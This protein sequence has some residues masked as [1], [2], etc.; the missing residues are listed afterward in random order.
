MT[1]YAPPAWSPSGR[2]VFGLY[3]EVIKSG[4]V[5]ETIAL[6]RP[7]ARSYT[8]VGRL[9]TACDVVLVHASI[10][11]VH[12]VLQFDAQGAL[13]LYD[14][15]S[16][17]GS[18]VNKRRIPAE[19]FVR[20]EVGDVLAFGE[21]TRR[22]A[23]C[24]PVERMPAES[25]SRTL[26]TLR[27]HGDP[28][29][30]GTTQQEHEHDRGVSWG[31]RQD[32]EEEEERDQEEEEEARMVATKKEQLP[33]YLRHLT[34]DDRPYESSLRPSQ[35]HPKDQRLYEQVQTRIR[36]MENLKLE[37]ARILA[38]QH[39][40][41]GLSAGQQQ[42]VLRNEERMEALRKDIEALEARIH[43]KNEQRA[44]A[45]GIRGAVARTKRQ[46]DPDVYGYSSDEDEFYD[47]TSANRAKLA[48]RK[49]KM[50]DT[51]TALHGNTRDSSAPGQKSE[52]LTAE[53]IR[54]NVTQLEAN[55]S[56]LQ[57]DV[58]A[59]SRTASNQTAESK[60]EHEMDSL[61]SFMATTST[62]LQMS[63]VEA[64]TRQKQAVEEELK[65]QKQ[66]LAVA[67]PAL[68]AL[69]IQKPIVN[70]VEGTVETNASTS[71]TSPARTRV[72]VKRLTIDAEAQDEAWKSVVEPE[73]SVAKE[74]GTHVDDKHKMHPAGSKHGPNTIVETP[75]PESTGPKRRRI[76]GPAKDAWE[77]WKS[78][79]SDEQRRVDSNLLEGGDPSW[80]PPA[81]QTGDGRTALNDKYG[82]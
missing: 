36:K 32:A 38:K 71:P 6:P 15:R 72:H 77:H 63:H 55:L 20:L 48:A 47:R 2:N 49:Q 30:A 41:D 68:A 51:S 33:E 58:T 62:Q 31:F 82:Y 37:R 17:H 76:V 54:A 61:D 25:E 67:T 65:R 74:I 27:E 59:A 9:A 50:M 45:S 69:P 28:T 8:F 64:L 60:E 44:T 1:Q 57:D 22:V 34:E 70:P 24:G 52:I 13:F 18:I 5:V 43:A 80:V 4:V 66:L 39:T 21:S 40:G 56:K 12:A 78:D 75:E 35:V 14:L 73:A 29:R 42:T 3:L 81:N 46:R 11:R 79:T 10:S 23:V 26:A 16:T 19:A 53:S 7:T